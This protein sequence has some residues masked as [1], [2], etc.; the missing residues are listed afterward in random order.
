MRIARR[1]SAGVDLQMGPMVDMVFLL[2]VFFMVQAQAVG[3]RELGLHLPQAAEAAPAPDGRR[4][5]I[6]PGGQVVVDGAPVDGTGGRE[7]PGLVALLRRFRE[8]CDARRSPAL[9][10]LAP[11]DEVPHQR[12][13]DVL[14]ACAEAGLA[15][16]TFAGIDGAGGEG[17]GRAR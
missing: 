15:G 3:E 14:N 10:T 8:G 13:T 2:L 9:V 12:I 6:R 1:R 7:L 11:A 16:V 17:D 5:E 4:I